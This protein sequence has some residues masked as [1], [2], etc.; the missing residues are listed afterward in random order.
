V[1][2][3]ADTATHPCTNLGTDVGSNIAHTSTDGASN[4]CVPELH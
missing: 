4:R 2:R 1:H 3:S